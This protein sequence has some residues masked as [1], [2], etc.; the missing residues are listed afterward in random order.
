MDPNLDPI[1]P[2]DQKKL[3]LK[4]KIKLKKGKNFHKI[5]EYYI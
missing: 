5:L 4:K 2:A 3:I 1:K